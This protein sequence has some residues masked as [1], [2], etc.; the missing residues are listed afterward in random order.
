MKSVFAA[1]VVLVASANA[2][3]GQSVS[4]ADLQAQIDAEM[5]AGNEYT[6]LIADPD[7]ARALA[8][9]K[10]MLRSGDPALVKIALEFGLYS[11]EPDVRFLALQ[12]FFEG[13][14]ALELHVDGKGLDAND[15]AYWMN[16]LFTAAVNAEGVAKGVVFVGKY[17]AGQK[18]YLMNDNNDCRVRHT[19]NGTQIMLNRV[20]QEFVLT[21]DGALVGKIG[22][23]HGDAAVRIP[24]N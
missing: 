8:A 3:L 24:L 19:E 12:G 11:P 14:P 22:I 7:P 10:V 9:M 17:D 13:Q 6:A 5:K 2:G 16:E 1:A 15:F 23:E 20:W 18:C 4:V 21:D